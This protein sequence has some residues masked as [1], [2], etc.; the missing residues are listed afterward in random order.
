MYEPIKTTEP[1]HVGG[2]EVKPLKS[3]DNGFNHI[4]CII[5]DGCYLFLSGHA[6]THTYLQWIPVEIINSLVN[7]L[8][9][10]ASQQPE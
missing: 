4:H 8:R 2:V 5:D 7:E 3:W 9:I 6:G 10:V 1:I